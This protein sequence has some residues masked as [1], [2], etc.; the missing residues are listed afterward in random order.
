MLR[1]RALPRSGSLRRRVAEG[2][3]RAIATDLNEIGRRACVGVGCNAEAADGPA[4]MIDLCSFSFSHW[5]Q[6]KLAVGGKF[7]K[8]NF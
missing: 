8:F 7:F 5:R 6:L 3:A 4:D 1:S 2:F